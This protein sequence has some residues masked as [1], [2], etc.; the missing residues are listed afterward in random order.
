V[1][2]EGKELNVSVTDG[3]FCG[4]TMVGLTQ[5]ER[6]NYYYSHHYDDQFMIWGFE[7]PGKQ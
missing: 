1:S 5:K 6:V 7:I 2:I 3:L 4:S